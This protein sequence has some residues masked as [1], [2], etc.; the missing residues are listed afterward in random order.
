KD[1]RGFV[2]LFNPNYRQLDAE[3]TLDDSIGLTDA[4]GKRFVLRQLYPDLGEGSLKAGPLRYGQKVKLAMNGASA[5]VLRLEPLD[6]NIAKPL[7]SGCPGQVALEGDKLKLTKVVGEPGAKSG[8]SVILPYEK[9]IASLLVNG[10]PVAFTQ[11]GDVVTAS[12]T[13]AGR[14]FSK[15]QQIGIYDANFKARTFKGSFS[16]PKR[17]MAQLAARKKAWPIPYNEAELAATWTAPHRLLMFVNIA[18]PKDEMEVTMK[19]DGKAVEVKKAYSSVYRSNPK[20]TFL[21]FYA[22][23]SDLKP[24]KKYSVTVELP[25]LEAGQFQGLF[26]DNVEPEQTAVLGK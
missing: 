11:T 13:F 14:K 9:K 18:D 6:E 10:Q 4:A 17:V 16:V 19:I 1:G 8:I 22:D 24:D 20:N 25:E 12:L 21:G 5:I 7:L 23:L 3:F 15:C 26:F 2:F